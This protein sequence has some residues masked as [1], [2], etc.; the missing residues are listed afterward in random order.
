MSQYQIVWLSAGG[1]RR[2][3]FPHL[4]RGATMQAY[5]SKSPIFGLCI[6]GTATAW[7]SDLES[8]YCHHGVADQLSI[9]KRSSI[10]WP[11]CA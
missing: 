11:I 7:Y 2:M 5:A 9:P 6:A 4:K 1:C 3:Y 10:H 8:G